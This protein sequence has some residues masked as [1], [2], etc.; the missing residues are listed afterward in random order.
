MMMNI[1]AKLKSVSVQRQLL[2]GLGIVVFSHAGFAREQVDQRITTSDSPYVEI[3][4]LNGSADI[5]GW[6]KNEVQVTGQLSDD[7]EEF[8]FEKDGND[9]VIKVEI[10]KDPGHWR[11]WKK[12]DGDDLKIYVPR[13]SFVDYTSINADV[14]LQDLQHTVNVEVINGDVDVKKVNGRVSLESV[15][16][17]ITL[18]DVEGDVAVETV[19][20]DINGEHRGSKDLRLDSVNG[21]IDI[22]TNSPEVKVT[23]VNGNIDLALDTITDLNIET[24]NGRVEAAMTLAPKGDVRASSVGGSMSLAFQRSV[25]ARFD[26]QAHAGGRIINDISDDEMQKAK[27]GPRRW[28]EFT[29]NGGDG[30]VDV[31]TVSGRIQLGVK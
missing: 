30:R 13:A 2:L 23:S 15:N 22:R 4:H 26:I 11:N 5:I 14:S 27:Y 1:L 18:R 20:G 17:D 21:D 3:E 16:G 25:S 19:N 24:V 29:H 31:S 9:I 7:T 12:S 8:I 6:D 10:A 28:L